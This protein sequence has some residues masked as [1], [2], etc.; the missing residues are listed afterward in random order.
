MLVTDVTTFPDRHTVT[1]LLHRWKDGDAGALEALMPIVYD[2]L[3]RL[4]RRHMAAERNDHTLQH[5]ALVHEAY[6]ELVD[7]NVGWN[8]RAHFF[9]VAARAMRRILVDHARGRNRDKRGGDVVRVGLDKA[10]D[11]PAPSAGLDLE[12]LDE[13][14]SRLG[15]VDSRKAEIIEM[16]YFGGLSQQELSDVLGVSLATVNR[17]LSWAKDWLRAELQL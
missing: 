10:S 8:N 11:T 2:E 9:A 3:R 1:V 17:D 15:E 12:V 14:L 6:L 4:A 5:T 16:R 7:M 13:A